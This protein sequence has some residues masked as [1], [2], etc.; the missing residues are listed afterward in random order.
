MFGWFK[1]LFAKKPIETKIPVP[2]QEPGDE[3][4][5]GDIILTPEGDYLYVLGMAEGKV[6][7][8][9]PYQW[10]ERVLVLDVDDALSARV[11]HGFELADE[12][13]H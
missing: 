10:G 5:A 8:H 1:K 7:T 6:W 13:I 12:D 11:D 4:V 9:K 3:L 2:P